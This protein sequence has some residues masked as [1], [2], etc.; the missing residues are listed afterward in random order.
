M[1]T[2]LLRI[3]TSGLNRKEL[4]VPLVGAESCPVFSGLQGEKEGNVECQARSIE[5]RSHPCRMVVLER[6]PLGILD[7]PDALLDYHVVQNARKKVAGVF[8]L[9]VDEEDVEAARVELL[10]EAVED[11]WAL[12]VE[13]NVE[14]VHRQ[15]V[16]CEDEHEDEHEDAHE[17]E[18]SQA[19][20]LFFVKDVHTEAV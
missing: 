8:Q 18:H 12:Y 1:K 13:E 7:E 20:E 14:D 3:K 5:K 6:Y 15:A 10:K 17:D 4:C 9:E 19:P 2:E 11:Q 16:E